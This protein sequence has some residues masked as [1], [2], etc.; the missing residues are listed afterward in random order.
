MRILLLLPL[1]FLLSGCSIQKFNQPPM[2]ASAIT[3]HER[4]FG[5]DASIPVATGTRIGVKLGWGSVVW[6][7]IPCSTNKVYSAPISD[8][9]SLG[10]SINPFDTKINE[11]LQTGWEGTPPTPRYPKLFGPTTVTN[12][13]NVVKFVNTNS[14]PK[15]LISPK[16]K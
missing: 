15:I 6:E 11:D 5:L 10:Q 9:F 2:W 1:I 12:T 3:S 7:V 13:V 4:F 14:T 8:T 16:N